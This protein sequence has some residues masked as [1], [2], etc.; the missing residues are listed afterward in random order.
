MPRTIN[1]DATYF[2]WVYFAWGPVEKLTFL[3]VH[4]NEMSNHARKA[5]M[6]TKPLNIRI[7]KKGGGRKKTD[8]HC[9]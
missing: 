2:Q 6:S 1:Q 3:C 7:L 4:A 9:V 5:W 8:N